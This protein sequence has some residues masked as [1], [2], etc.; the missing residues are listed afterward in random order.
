MQVLNAQFTAS[1]V[2]PVVSKKHLKPKLEH[3]R[4]STR[5]KLTYTI[6]KLCVYKYVI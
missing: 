1:K 2:V 4:L 5:V 6:G 3:Q